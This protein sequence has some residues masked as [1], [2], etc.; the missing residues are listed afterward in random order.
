MFSLNMGDF[1]IWKTN[2]KSNELIIV[3]ITFM[4]SRLPLLYKHSTNS[5]N[6]GFMLAT[7]TRLVDRIRTTMVYL[8]PVPVLYRA[9]RRF[10]VIC[11]T[12]LPI[13]CTLPL[14]HTS[15]NLNVLSLELSLQ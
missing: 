11:V 14:E 6:I 15:N 2:N 10:I 1:F 7:Q 4:I 8:R 9:N 3:L 5:V 12:A 13:L